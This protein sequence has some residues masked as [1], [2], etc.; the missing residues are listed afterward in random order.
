MFKYVKLNMR[1]SWNIDIP[2]EGSGEES[3][4]YKARRSFKAI[5]SFS[6]SSTT[7]C[8]YVTQVLAIG[9]SDSKDD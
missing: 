4:L 7:T 3:R 9:L 5:T 1:R 8:F 6:S 2:S